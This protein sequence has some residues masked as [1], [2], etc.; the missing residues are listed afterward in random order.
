MY[1]R[2]DA[3]ALVMLMEHRQMNLP[4]SINLSNKLLS[5]CKEFEYY[6]L[7]MQIYNEMVV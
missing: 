7:A 5:L 1:K 3:R 4:M 2:N 6:T